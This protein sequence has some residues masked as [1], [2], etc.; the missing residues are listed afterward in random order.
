MLTQKEMCTNIK[1]YFCNGIKYKIVVFAS[2][3]KIVILVVTT[4]TYV[5][6]FKLYLDLWKIS[7][8]LGFIC[9]ILKKTH[10]VVKIKMD[11]FMN[12]TCVVNGY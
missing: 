9:S 8:H 12:V 1:I 6:C 3:M 11:F 5:K 10:W 4:T 2:E 7:C